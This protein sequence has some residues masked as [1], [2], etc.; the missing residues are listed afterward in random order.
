[1]QQVIQLWSDVKLPQESIEVDVDMAF[2]QVTGRIAYLMPVKSSGQGKMQSSFSNLM[3][4]AATMLILVS[5]CYG[6]WKAFFSVIEVNAIAGIVENQLP[7]GSVMWLKTGATIKYPR[8]LQGSTRT[9]TLRGTAY[10]DIEHIKEK[11]FEILGVN[12]FVRVLGT[13]FEMSTDS[14]ETIVKVTEGLVELASQDREI[15]LELKVGESASFNVSERIMSEQKTTAISPGSWA[16]GRMVFQNA[17]L[18][19]VIDEVNNYFD[20][21]IRLGNS[22]L[23]NCAITTQFVDPD[24]EEILEELSILLSLKIDRKDDAIYLGG[25]DCNH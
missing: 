22:D 2:S 3:K 4:I 13:E 6:G 5:I 21:D 17:F 11:P 1:M 16:T 15:K 18:S 10:F 8:R 12:S 24:L 25:K 14:M 20:S 9:V 23:H 7:D 19:D